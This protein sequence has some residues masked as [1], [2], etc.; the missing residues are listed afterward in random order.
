[1]EENVYLAVTVHHEMK[2]GEELKQGRNLE[3]RDD[4]ET[5]EGC[6]LL[7]FFPWLV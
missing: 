2:S 4:A 5:M 3:V 7:A 6:C 1:V